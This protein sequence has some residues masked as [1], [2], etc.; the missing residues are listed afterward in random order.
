MQLSKHYDIGHVE[1][2]TQRYRTDIGSTPRGVYCYAD[3]DG[4]VIITTVDA[5]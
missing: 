1:K 3:S 5:E 2:E 4:K